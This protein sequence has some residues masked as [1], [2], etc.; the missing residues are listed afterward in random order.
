MDSYWVGGSAFSVGPRSGQLARLLSSVEQKVFRE[1][2]RKTVAGCEAPLIV[3][4][5]ASGLAAPLF[6]L[7]NRAATALLLARLDH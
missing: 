2:R 3:V 5:T 6:S 1:M 4:G 7:F